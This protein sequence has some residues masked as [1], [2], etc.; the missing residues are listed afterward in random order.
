MKFFARPSVPEELSI[1]LL[2]RGGLSR[3]YHHVMN[4]LLC[5][6]MC[7]SQSDGEISWS[8]EILGRKSTE[9]SEI[10]DN[11]YCVYNLL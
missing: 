2:A 10:M 9:L 6:N 1:P 4:Q 7:C 11:L 3:H 8:F 5:Y